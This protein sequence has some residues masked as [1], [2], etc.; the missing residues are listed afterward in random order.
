MACCFLAT[1]LVGQME[2]RLRWTCWR[3]TLQFDLVGSLARQRIDRVVGWFLARL[4]ST[5]EAQN[6]M[7]SR[8]WNRNMALDNG[9]GN[10]SE[11]KFSQML[12]VCAASPI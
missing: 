9:D 5:G 11:R 1:I 6:A 8:R 2:G 7:L 10:L 12:V 3:Y 4:H